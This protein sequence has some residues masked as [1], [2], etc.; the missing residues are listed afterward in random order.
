MDDDF[1]FEIPVTFEMKVWLKDDEQDLIGKATIEFSAGKYPTRENIK[2]WIKKTVEQTGMEVC[3]PQEFTEAYMKEK[4]GQSF[5]IPG[6]DEW[7]E[8]FSV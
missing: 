4:T 1:D 6:P 3:S 2:N 5:S 7:G 8:D